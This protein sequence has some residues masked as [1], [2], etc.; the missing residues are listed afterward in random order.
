MKNL[1]AVVLALTIFSGTSAS[2]GNL[3]HTIIEPK[4]IIEDAKAGS[5]S[6]AMVIVALTGL[7]MLA[8]IAQ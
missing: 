3:E 7:F 5:S 4:M 6:S 8:V 2:A 1:A